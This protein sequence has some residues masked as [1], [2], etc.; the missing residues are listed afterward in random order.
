MKGV[1][2]MAAVC[3]RVASKLTMT[4]KVGIDKNGKDKIA[5]KTIGKLMV[6]AK[7]DDVFEIGKAVSALKLYPMIALERVDENTLS[8]A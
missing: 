5:T 2:I 7:D 3:T 4:M 1:I 6:D 8:Q